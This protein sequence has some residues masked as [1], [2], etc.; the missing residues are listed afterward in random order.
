MATTRA[1]LRVHRL[2]DLGFLDQN[3]AEGKRILTRGSL[4]AGWVPRQLAVVGTL[5]HSFGSVRGA[6]KASPVLKLDVER[7]RLLIKLVDTFNCG[8][9]R[10]KS[11]R[12]SGS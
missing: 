8:E 11:V 12:N 3:G 4:T 7:R 10:W 6:S 9:W 5:L 2:G 1:R